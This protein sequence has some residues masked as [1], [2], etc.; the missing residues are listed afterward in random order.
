[1]QQLLGQALLRYAKEVEGSEDVIERA[2]I[3][4]LV[5]IAKAPK[6]SPLVNVDTDSVIRFLQTI[7]VVKVKQNVSTSA[8]DKEAN[9][10]FM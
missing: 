8:K 9:T 5:G 2:V 3:P 6:N 1:M 4:T 7:T 10:F